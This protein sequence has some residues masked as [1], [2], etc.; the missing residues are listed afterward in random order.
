MIVTFCVWLTSEQ[1]QQHDLT[2]SLQD[3]PG[4]L[5][6]VKLIL[7]FSTAKGD[8]G[9][10]DDNQNYKTL[11][12]R[13]NNIFP[14]KPEVAERSLDSVTRGFGMKFC[15]LNLASVSFECFISY[16][17]HPYICSNLQN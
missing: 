16:S 15:V 2:P 7:N 3:D 14:S 4:K 5:V 8:R 10:S 1:Q 6:P 9:S 12:S 17:F 11:N 13:F